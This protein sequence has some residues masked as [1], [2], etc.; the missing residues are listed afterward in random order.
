MTT[1]WKIVDKLPPSQPAIPRHHLNHGSLS[2]SQESLWFMQQLDPDNFAYN[3]SF[4][5]KITGGIDHLSLENALNEMV[6]RHDILRTIY[7]NQGGSPVQ[8]VQPHLPFSLPYVDYSALPGLE[9]QKTIQKYASEHGNLP[10]HLQQGPLVRFAL[11]HAAPGEDYLFWGMHHINSDAWSREIFINELRRHYKTIGSEEQTSLPELPIQYLDYALWQREWLN[12][13]VLAAYTEHWKNILSGEL[14]ILEL[15]TDQ[16]RPKLQTSQGAR[17]Y[18]RFSKSLFMQ[19]EEFCKGERITPFQLFL[20]AYAILLMRYSGQE[21]IIIGCP[22][23]NR[24][25]AELEKIYG[26]FVNTLPIRINLQ[27]NPKIRDFLNRVRTLMLDAFAWQ[28]APF[29]ALVSEISPERD[30]SRNPVFQV[31]INMRNIPMHFSEIKGLKIEPVLIENVP[32]QFDLSLEFDNEGDS[33]VGSFVYNIDLFDENTIVHMAAHFNSLVME[34]LGD[35]DR[36]LSEVEM[37]SR[38]ERKRVILDWNDTSSDFPNRCIHELISEQAKKT[39]DAPAV[40]CNGT[41]LTYKELEKRSNQ[42]AQYLVSNGVKAESRVGIYLPRS[43]S[44]IVTILAILKAGGAYVPLDISLPAERIGFMMTDSDSTAI[45]TVSS[46]ETQIPIQ[47]K[48][49]FLDTEIDAINH[50]SINPPALVTGPDALL[51]VMYTSG[52][53]GRP[54]AVMNVHKGIVNYLT[55]VQKTFGFSP[56]DRFIQ[57]TTLSFDLSVLEILGTLF[58]GATVLLMD[59]EQMRNPEYINRAIVEYQATCLSLVPTMLRAIC[60]SALAGDH[61]KQNL[62]LIMPVGEVL[63]DTDVVLARQAFGEAVKLVN[64]YGP[65]EC[66]V[67]STTYNVPAAIPK[68]LQSIPIGKPINNVRAYVLDNYFHPVPV[69]AKGELFIGG[70]GVGR[71]YWNLPELTEEKFLPD[72]FH[73]GSR[74]YRTG[75]IV[76]QM[77]DGTIYFLG[78]LDNQ[79]KIRGYRVEL[80]EIEAVMR[81]FPDVKDA[82]VILRDQAGSKILAGYIT[83]TNGKPEQIKAELHAYLERHLPFYMLPS[84]LMV[85]DEMPLTYNG[86]INRQA[87]PLSMSEIKLGEYVHPRNDIEKKVVAIWKDVLG[88]DRIGIRDNFF[89]LGGHSLLAVRLFTRIEEE[90]GQNLPLLLLFREGT[91][92]AMASALSGEVDNGFPDGVAPIQPEGEQVPV[93]ILSA[94]IYMRELTRALGVE[95]PVFGLYPFEDGKLTYRESVE[96]VARIYYRC[97]TNFDPNGPYILLGHSGQGFFALELARLLARE[98]KEVAFLGLLDTYPPGSTKR[99]KWV[100]RMKIHLGN[101]QNENLIGV[102]SYIFQSLR[103]LVFRNMPALWSARSGKSLER[104]GAI[105]ERVSDLARAYHPDVFTGGVTIFSAE[106]RPWYIRWNPMDRWVDFLTGKVEIIATPG[107]HSS[108]FKPPHVA[109]LAEKIAEILRTNAP[110]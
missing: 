31:A 29:E 30:L 95:R 44:I 36:P 39:P 98:G 87:L 25:R 80:G 6:R 34:L 71:G 66:S 86:K 33:L 48:K 81:E 52:S 1:R 42:L 27:D 101:I 83:V 53:T 28:A 88:L 15:P 84:Y 69:G 47:I 65:S 38:T 26:V 35:T 11:L 8:I 72:P 92:E 2:F 58:F 62:R 45:I 105:Q 20:A 89:A 102:L 13:D 14:P 12:G 46:L 23:A 91:V 3:S 77:Q 43:E 107:D 32:A 93:Y 63:H 103:R 73:Q 4:L 21:D 40:I 106:S 99:V 97:L 49:I 68:G 90:F 37:L 55:F 18:F 94:D 7:Q 51:Y 24:S 10:Y 56:L 82:A 17:Y 64:Q 74:M 60:E 54:K 96:E 108:I 16:P 79:V 67:V 104:K 9:R 109:I 78:R 41:T 61:K 22:F 100:D 59:D 70:E 85:L 19:I 57:L 76:R 110:K 50:S 5:Y 75:D